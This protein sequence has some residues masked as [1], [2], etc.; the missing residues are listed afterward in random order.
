M[1]IVAQVHQCPIPH[2][3][4]YMYLCWKTRAA[5]KEQQ[6]A[7]PEKKIVV[8]EYEMKQKNSDSHSEKKMK[9]EKMLPLKLNVRFCTRHFMGYISTQYFIVIIILLLIV[10]GLQG[11]IANY[12]DVC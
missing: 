7:G 3:I 10:S 8:N 2:S 9:E 12:M 6:I 1:V 11:S 5:Q 4:L